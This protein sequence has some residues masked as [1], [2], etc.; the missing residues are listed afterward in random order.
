MNK[1]FKIKMISGSIMFLAAL[2]GV[3][4]SEIL[5]V[6]MIFAIA[7]LIF[8]EWYDIAH[9]HGKLLYGYLLF[10]PALMSALSLR[11]VD[12]GEY[13]IL[14]AL[15]LIVAVDCCA[16]F[17]GKFFGGKKL[18]AQISPNKTISGLI[19]GIFGA[20]LSVHIVAAMLTNN[21][22]LELP[23]FWLMTLFIIVLAVLEQA[24]DFMESYFKRQ[25]KIKDSSKL[26]PGHGGILDRLDGTIFV[27]PVLWLIIM[28]CY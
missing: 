23:G 18:C 5:F 8:S 9:P 12:N 13:I 7:L 17:G 19:T 10:L 11:M 22:N 14:L 2:L 26:I 20:V 21:T 6:V 1:D 25:F 16:Y 3:L 15:V 4:W 28:I 24:G 27:L